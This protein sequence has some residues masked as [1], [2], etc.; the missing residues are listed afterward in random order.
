MAFNR[1][2]SESENHAIPLEQKVES[3]DSG[4]NRPR[5]IAECRRF[6]GRFEHETSEE[7]RWMRKRIY[8]IDADT[9]RRP[10]GRP[11]VRV[12]IDLSIRDRV[13]EREAS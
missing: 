3:F 7:N 4:L 6:D 11:R 12:R 8:F 1:G 5:A 13:L 10:Q 2:R 9:R